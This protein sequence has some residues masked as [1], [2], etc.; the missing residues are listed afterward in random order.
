[1]KEKHPDIIIADPD[2]FNA[3]Y[4]SSGKERYI[5]T[6]NDYAQTLFQ[7]SVIFG[8]VD[9]AQTR[10]VTHDHVKAAAH[11]IANSFGK[12]I[13][14][15]WIWTLKVGQ[16]VCA[17]LMGV[18]TGHLEDIKW[19]LGFMASFVIGGILLLVEILKTRS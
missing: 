14:P 5:K 3:G 19:I 16:Y 6:V 11:S 12:P 1:M 7:K 10:E 4:T 18:A 13:T 9:K 8:D 17:G 15:R 2:L